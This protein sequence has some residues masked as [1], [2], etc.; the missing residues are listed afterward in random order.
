[1]MPMKIEIFSP[2]Y[3]RPDSCTTQ[4]YLPLCTYV[5]ARSEKR[6]YVRAG[7][8][9]IAVPNAVQGNVSRVRNYI[10]DNFNPVLILDDDIRRFGRWNN[11][12]NQKLTTDEAMEFV[13]H[14]FILARQLGARMWGMNL[15]PDKGAYREYTPFAFRS[16]VLGPVQ[17]FVNMDLRYDESLPLKEDYDL[18]LQVLN[19]YRRT[20]RFNMYHYVC[21]QHSSVGGCATYRTM[22]RERKQF[23]LLQ[24]KWGSDI[25]Q[26]DRQGGQVN[27]KKRTNW[28]INPVVRVPIHGV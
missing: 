1:M 24:K 6:D 15:L 13:E 8:R 9:V 22:E 19:K 11:Q 16:V 4:E 28:D 5:V 23:Y 27:Q 18:S 17:G 14:A 25:V 20:L 21:D 12:E 26:I 2:S 3:H 10:L 7:R